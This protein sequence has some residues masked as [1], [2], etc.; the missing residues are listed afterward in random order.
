ML[1][2]FG[3]AACICN[4]FDIG[5][6][7]PKWRS[8]LHASHIADGRSTTLKDSWLWA[9]RHSP[10]YRTVGPYDI[11]ILILLIP[12]K[13]IDTKHTLY[14][15]APNKVYFISIKDIL[16]ACYYWHLFMISSWLVIETPINL[17]FL[18]MSSWLGNLVHQE[19]L[20]FL[21]Q[22]SETTPKGASITNQTWEVLKWRL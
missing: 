7:T 18:S 11:F 21:K 16:E 3:W 1:H 5:R 13:C 4:V 20:S 6:L 12:H 8:L 19:L 14:N 2:I 10:T 22:T 17:G 9:L 15:I